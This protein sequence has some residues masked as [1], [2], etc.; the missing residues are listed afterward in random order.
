MKLMRHIL[1]AAIAM[2]LCTACGNADEESGAT[3][4]AATLVLHIGTAAPTRAGSDDI[5][6]MHSLRVVLLDADGVV[7]YNDYIDDLYRPDIFGDKGGGIIELDYSKHRFIRTTPGRK[8]I[9]LIANEG[10]I[11]QTTGSGSGSQT[12]TQLLGSKQAGAE[13]FEQMVNAISFTPGYNRNIP[14]SSYY[15]FTI[16]EGERFVEKDFWLVHAAAK[17]EFS[18]INNR[19]NP[20]RIDRM[21]ISSLADNMYLMA[22]VGS[23][24]R[25]K[26]LDGTP[27]WW[28]DWLAAVA[29]QTADDP[30]NPDN[31]EVNRHYGWISDYELPEGVSHRET[32]IIGSGSDCT[33]PVTA[34]IANPM[35]L[36]ATYC[37][38]SRNLDGGAQ[39]YDI[40]ISATDTGTNTS[41]TGTFTLDKIGALFRNTN[42]R[43][44]ITL[45][46]D[47]RLELDVMLTVWDEETSGDIEF[48]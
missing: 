10:S 41:A 39:K 40:T 48:H 14:L 37:P 46:G 20:V 4:G 2:L 26:N 33:V 30:K 13:G 1:T 12:L 9:F 47:S 42:V 17:F 19:L 31:E 21:S 43:V 23:S 3:S 5:E 32:E 16:D 18:F 11:G 44:T 29:R 25:Y 7:E 45:N 24:D 15:E 6:S 36:P 27:T 22:N 35:T 38:E 28:V 8:K 34:D